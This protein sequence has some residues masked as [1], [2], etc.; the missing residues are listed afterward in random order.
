MENTNW[1]VRGK[2]FDYAAFVDYL[3]NLTNAYPIL[4]IE[5][6]MDGV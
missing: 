4:S 2:I 6:G 3:E 1:R 5:D